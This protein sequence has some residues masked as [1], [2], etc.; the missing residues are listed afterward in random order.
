MRMP[1]Y[2]LKL[3]LGRLPRDFSISLVQV[4][5]IVCGR[6][7]ETC[8]AHFRYAECLHKKGD[9]YADREQLDQ[10]GPLI[11]ELYIG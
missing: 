10:A 9:V 4:K 7:A 11:R 3:T 5:E 2:P 6:S 8:V 1:V